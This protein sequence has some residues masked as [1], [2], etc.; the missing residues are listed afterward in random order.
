MVILILIIQV[1][2][3]FTMLVVAVEVALDLLLEIHPLLEFN[4]VEE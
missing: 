3:I 1:L 4:Q 2:V